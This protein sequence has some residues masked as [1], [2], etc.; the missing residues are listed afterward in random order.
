MWEIE[1]VGVLDEA[2]VIARIR[3]GLAASTKVRPQ[4]AE[5]WRPIGGHAPFAAALDERPSVARSQAVGFVGALVVV[6]ILLGGWFVTGGRLILAKGADGL[7]P[8]K[9]I[10]IVVP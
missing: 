5:K 2:Q 8:D 3:R 7:G 9:R 6:G 10:W 1:G 4:G